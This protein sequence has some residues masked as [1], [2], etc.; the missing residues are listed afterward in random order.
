MQYINPK[1]DVYKAIGGWQ[2]RM[3]AY[4]PEDNMLDVVQTGFGPYRT[5]KDAED[6]AESWA[7]VEGLEFERTT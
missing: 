3:M 6:D 4:Y 2:S 5:K 1:I 7:K